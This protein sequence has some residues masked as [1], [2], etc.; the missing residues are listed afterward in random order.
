MA[1]I[2][3]L[4]EALQQTLAPNAKIN[5]MTFNVHQRKLTTVE[6][7]R[8]DFISKEFGSKEDR[9]RRMGETMGKFR[10]IL[11]TN[12]NAKKG[13]TRATDLQNQISKMEDYLKRFLINSATST[14]FFDYEAILNYYEALANGQG[15]SAGSTY[16]KMVFDGIPEDTD[17]RKTFVELLLDMTKDPKTKRPSGTMIDRINAAIS[18]RMNDTNIQEM[19][20]RASEGFGQSQLFSDIATHKEHFLIP[21]R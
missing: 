6:E 15:A 11:L 8:E 19:M 21:P 3:N 2:G 17:I 16:T 20:A 18:E 5:Q 1:G 7:A 4:V 9:A 14:R 12:Q 13:T 10:A